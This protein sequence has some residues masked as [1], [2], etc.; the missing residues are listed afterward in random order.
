LYSEESLNSIH[1]RVTKAVTELLE[2]AQVNQKN[3]NDILIFLMNGHYD[4]QIVLAGYSKFIL[5]PGMKGLYDSYRGEFLINYLNTG[6]S[7]ILES[8]ESE[9]EKERYERIT[10]NLELMIY[11]HFWEN[12]ISLKNLKQLANLINCEVYD[13]ENP[14]PEKSKF[15]FITE[16][17]RD[18]YLKFNLDLGKLIQESYHSQLRNA[19]AHGQYGLF[20]NGIIQLYNFKGLAHEI[21]LISYADWEIRFLITAL[22]F[23]E[24]VIQKKA[25]LVK[26][27]KENPETAVWVPKN[28]FSS[29]QRV[30]IEWNEFSK[31]YR[32]KT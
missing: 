10:I 19:F 11:S 27:G 5:G 20:G 25:L 8:I 28:D 15:E 23:Y 2:L 13:W 9:E 22:V 29:Y 30:I 26:L 17:I 3:P 12:E 6:E 16:Q 31:M 4:E 18:I 21:Q 14:I 7:K 24:L 1:P 32:Y